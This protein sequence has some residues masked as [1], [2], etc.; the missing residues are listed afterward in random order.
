[1]GRFDKRKRRSFATALELA[2]RIAAERL[3]ATESG[4]LARAEVDLMRAHGTHAVLA[5]EAFMR[6]ADSGSELER[7]FGATRT[8]G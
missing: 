8:S 7:M 4:I 2:P 6:A 1:M 3:V 5:G